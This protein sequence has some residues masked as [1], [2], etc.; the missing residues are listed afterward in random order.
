MRERVEPGQERLPADAS[1]IT[2][3]PYTCVALCL[4]LPSNEVQYPLTLPA[5][6]VAP[7]AVTFFNAS[8]LSGSMSISPAAQST[9]VVTMP[10]NA[11]TSTDHPSRVST[12]STARACSTLAASRSRSP[13]R[14]DA[15]SIAST[16]GSSAHILTG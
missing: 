9:R 1:T 12:R 3:A 6:T 8:L 13:V 10:A 14:R 15:W 16:P 11:I 2:A 4:T 7:P 5:G